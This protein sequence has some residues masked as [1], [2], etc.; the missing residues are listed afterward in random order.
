MSNSLHRKPP[1]KMQ[2]GAALIVMLLLLVSGTLVL[3]INSL[4]SARLQNTRAQTT[5]DAL[6]QA[7]AA[8]IAYA[9]AVALTPAGSK[10]PGNLPCPD[11]NNDGIAETACGNA[12]GSTGQNLRL[13]RLPWKTLGIEDLRDSSGERLWYAVSS[14]FKN[15][16]AISVLNSDTPGSI[17]VRDTSG[18]ISHNGCIT[19]SLPKCPQPGSDDDAFGTG[20]VAVIIA[21]G[22]VLTRQTT[23]NPQDRSASGINTS[24]NYLDAATLNGLTFDNQSFTDLSSTSGFIQGDIRHSNG[25]WILNDKLI[26]ISQDQLMSSV[27][28]RVAAELKQCLNEYAAAD[29][30]F[31]RY[32]WAAKL[33]PTAPVSHDDTSG[34]MFGRI[35]DNPFDS[36]LSDSNYQMNDTW[37][38]NCNIN[39]NSGWWLNWKESVFY[40][41]ADAYKPIPTPN[42]T[43]SCG[44]C[45]SLSSSAA[46]NDKRFVV[47]VAGKKVTG[48]SRNNNA[49]KG[50]PA[51]YLEGGNQNAE[52]SGGYTFTQAG[53]SGTFNDT[54]VTP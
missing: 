44:T 4:S 15:N 49:D 33:D 7:K 12:S 2:H 36:T 51:N 16:T 27:Q 5:A 39:S 41:L 46:G 45:L 22:A 35:P 10:R 17:T 18:N 23:G 20:A 28:K 13:G 53:F 43:A 54:V 38:G 31:G 3:L 37:M 8:L 24:S 32:P 26:V 40:G 30:S 47:I 14:N 48:Q 11:I 52:Q 25:D 50:A 34:I 1:A 42:D 21:P 9:T 6:T 29:G 19:Y